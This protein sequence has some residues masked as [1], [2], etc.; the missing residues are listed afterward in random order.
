MQIFVSLLFYVAAL[1]CFKRHWPLSAVLG[2]G[3][4]VW[5]AAAVVHQ[6]LVR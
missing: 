3:F 2:V 5:A 4:S 1:V 6:W